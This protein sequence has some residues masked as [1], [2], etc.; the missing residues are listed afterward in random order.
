MSCFPN[1][2]RNGSL[3]WKCDIKGAPTGKLAGKTI[4]LKDTICVAGVPMMN[5]SKIWEG[6]TPEFDATIVTRILDAGGNIKGKAVCEDMCFSGSSCTTSYGPLKNPYDETRT[7]GGSSCGSGL[8]VARGEVDMAIGG[9]QGGSIRIPAA[10]CGL[11]GLKPT[12]GL[13]PYTGAIP[14]ETTLDHLGPITKTVK[15]CAILLE[16]LAGYDNG[17]DPRQIPNIQVPEY[18]KLIDSPITGK[19]IAVLK[20]GF[21]YC[22]PGVEEC[23]RKAL[24]VFSEIGATVEEVS[25]PL[26][27]DG[28]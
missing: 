27:Q 4:A 23:I 15:D 14:M 2:Y 13:V 5:G 22:D 25:I 18:T 28:Q 11:V 19:K 24:S 10:W 26:H 7:T 9:D 21:N 17:N 20:E 16:V 3:Y 1:L 8:L 6:Y 12:W